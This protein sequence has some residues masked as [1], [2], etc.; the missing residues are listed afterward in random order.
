MTVLTATHT[1]AYLLI[2]RLGLHQFSYSEVS[3]VHECKLPRLISVSGNS[4]W[5]NLTSIS[6]NTCYHNVETVNLR[7]PDSVIALASTSI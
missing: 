1:I 5:F 4:C 7:N 6:P 2:A 3:V